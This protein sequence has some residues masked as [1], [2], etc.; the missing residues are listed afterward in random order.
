MPLAADVTRLPE[1]GAAEYANQLLGQLGCAQAVVPVAHPEHPALTWARSG[2]MHVTG[3][4]KPEMC[5]AP[6]ASCAE[7][8]LEAL[9][10]FGHHSLHSLNGARLLSERA[11]WMG[12]VRQGAVSA[13]GSCRLLKTADGQ[14]A[15]N[16]ARNEDWAML[17]AWL[18]CTDTPFEPGSWKAVAEAVATQSTEMLVEQGC[19][20]GLP[21]AADRMPDTPG[22]WC[23]TLV[24]GIPAIPK[25]APL[26]LDL[27]AL[28]AGPLCT[29]L[30]QGMGARVIKV[31]STTRPDGARHGHA[32][33]YDLLNAGKASVM[34][35]L[36]SDHGRRQ[37]LG[38]IH[39]ADIVIESA[40]PRGLLQMGIDAEVLVKARPGLT[41]LGIHAYG[42]TGDAAHRVGF[43]DDVAVAGGLSSL[44]AQATGQP[45]FVGDAIADPLTGIH[46]ALAAWSAYQQGGGRLLSISMHEVVAQCLHFDLPG[47]PGA[48]RARYA[49]WSQLPLPEDIQPPQP[50]RADRPAARAGADTHTILAEF[51]LA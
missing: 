46:A 9:K 14:L 13:G 47:D 43:G 17:P 3:S 28:W 16:L 24:Q 26:V 35:D 21:L 31:E 20:M 8:A 15:L 23:Q 32:D 40:R 4:E 1:A 10:S 18:S 5:P 49:A 38:L 25:K 27:S 34:L 51:G 7:G 19:L 44:M 39:Q 36:S 48:I 30:L 11:A 37:L 42:R 6:I 22:R 50:R 33:F 12:L 41:W 29:H 45:M 2:L